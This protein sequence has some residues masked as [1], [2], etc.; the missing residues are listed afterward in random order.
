M[1]FHCVIFVLY[2]E[3]TSIQDGILSRI[4]GTRRYYC[5][6][7]GE[8]MDGVEEVVE[9]EGDGS[10]CTMSLWMCVAQTTDG[11]MSEF[12]IS[13]PLHTLSSPWPHRPSLISARWYGESLRGETT[14]MPWCPQA[15]SSILGGV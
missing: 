3:L 5:D 1:F 11:M 8:L 12:A 13:T 4:E 7:A 15:P 10:G 9:V 14:S 2:A 6:G